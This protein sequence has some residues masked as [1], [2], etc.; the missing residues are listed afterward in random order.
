MEV[1]KTNRSGDSRDREEYRWNEK[2]ELKKYS[3]E[4]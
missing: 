3:Q 1:D 2:R 4:I